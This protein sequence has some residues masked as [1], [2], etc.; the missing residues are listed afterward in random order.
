MLEMERFQPAPHAPK[1]TPV[2]KNSFRQRE[3]E[4]LLHVWILCHETPGVSQGDVDVERALTG[5]ATSS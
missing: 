5:Y 4:S 3:G 1:H 2:L